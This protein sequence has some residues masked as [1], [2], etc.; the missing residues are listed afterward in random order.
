VPIVEQV[1]Q[2]QHAGAIAVIIVDFS[3]ANEKET[4]LQSALTANLDMWESLSIPSVVV[5]HNYH[6]KILQSMDL[7]RGDVG[8]YK[9]QFVMANTEYAEWIQHRQNHDAMH[10]EL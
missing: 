10:D 1:S 2:A 9:D 6:E 4:A 3:D 5:S 8:G 7:V